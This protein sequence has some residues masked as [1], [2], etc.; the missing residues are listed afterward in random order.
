MSDIPT[1]SVDYTTVTAG[2]SE[3]LRNHLHGMLN[4]HIEQSKSVQSEI[5][6]VLSMLQLA[7]RIDLAARE[8][9]DIPGAIIANPDGSFTS[10]EYL[11]N[12]RTYHN[13]CRPATDPSACIA[14]RDKDLPPFELA[15]ESEGYILEMAHQRGAESNYTN[16]DHPTLTFSERD[17]IALVKE[18]TGKA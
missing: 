9:K 17:F 8:G 7:G 1:I 15:T 11:P 12:D 3:A 16:D 2:T 4:A 5:N 13:S 14:I 6:D 10:L 18:L